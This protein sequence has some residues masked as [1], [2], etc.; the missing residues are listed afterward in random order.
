VIIIAFVIA[1]LSLPVTVVTAT[2]LVSLPLVLIEKE[3]Q[4][5]NKSEEKWRDM[6]VEVPSERLPLVSLLFGALDNIVG[7]TAALVVAALIFALFRQ[8]MPILFVIVILV[9][10]LYHDFSRIVLFIG[11][12][13][14]WTEVGY[15]VGDIFGVMLGAVLGFHWIA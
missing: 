8:T 11:S 12:S 5:Q 1:L 14:L 2:F 15:L 7:K 10:L 3:I 6:G 9:P 4:W 13:G